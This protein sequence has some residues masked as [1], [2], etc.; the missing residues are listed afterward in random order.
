MGR[1]RLRRAGLITRSWLVPSLPMGLTSHELRFRQERRAPVEPLPKLFPN[2]SPAFT[3]RRE[4]AL[5][6]LA[7]P[8]PVALAVTGTAD[9]R[10]TDCRDRV[11]GCMRSRL[12]AASSSAGGNAE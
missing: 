10:R 2:P 6:A 8:V 3:T 4:G 1:K 7:V 9:V 11:G 12:R 5:L